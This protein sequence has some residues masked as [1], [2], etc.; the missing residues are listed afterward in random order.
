MTDKKIL[1]LYSNESIETLEGP[2][3]TLGS[4][5]NPEMILSGEFV[6]IREV[7]RNKNEPEKVRHHAIHVSKFKDIHL[8]PEVKKT[9]LK[10]A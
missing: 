10:E 5:Y 9:E 8:V 6:L 7:N 3:T 2:F 4:K 1:R